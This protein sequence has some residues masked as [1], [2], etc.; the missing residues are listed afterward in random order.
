MASVTQKC[1]YNSGSIR[2]NGTGWQL[3]YRK[4]GKTIYE[5][6][7]GTR[8]EADKVLRERLG[9]IESGNHVNKR[10]VTVGAYLAQWLPD[11]T[12]SKPLK[13]RTA[14]DYK[15][16]IDCYTGPIADIPLQKLE[17]SSLKALYNGMKARKLGNST[18]ATAY[19]VF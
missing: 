10:K 11:F 7:R 6:V 5:Q 4:N 19:T 13:P 8:K 15:Q 17:N 2:K 14:Q 3:R 18:I 9:K 12:D 16:K 1:A